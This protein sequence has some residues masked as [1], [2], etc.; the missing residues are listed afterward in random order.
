VSV[1]VR[2]LAE[3][4]PLGRAALRERLDTAGVRTQGQALVTS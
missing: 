3:K 1:V 4:G 2:A